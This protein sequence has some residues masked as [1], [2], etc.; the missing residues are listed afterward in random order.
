MK[1]KSL[2]QL[3]KLSPWTEEDREEAELQTHI[4]HYKAM[5]IKQQLLEEEACTEGRNFKPNL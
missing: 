1:L 3:P 2:E 4:E 5:S